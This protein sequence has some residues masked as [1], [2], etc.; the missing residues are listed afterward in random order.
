VKHVEVVVIIQ[1]CVR[2]HPAPAF[3]APQ[4]HVGCLLP[5]GAFEGGSLNC[6]PEMAM[7]PSKRG[8]CLDYKYSPFP[9]LPLF[10][11]SSSQHTH[12]HA[13]SST[14]HHLQYLIKPNTHQHYQQTTSSKCLTLGKFTSLPRLP[15]STS[16]PHVHSCELHTLYPSPRN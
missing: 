15:F 13:H 7:A 9:P 2:L 14:L 3:H 16:T 4:P 12:S 10:F 1:L 11:L 5:C 8:P 6:R